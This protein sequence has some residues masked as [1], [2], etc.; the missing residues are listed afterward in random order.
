MGWSQYLFAIGDGYLD[1]MKWL[2]EHGCP[3]DGEKFRTSSD[4]G[5]LDNMKL[6]REQSCPWDKDT[7]DSE[8]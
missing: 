4:N 6:L 1:N 7:L 2:R 3:W 8:G 5:C